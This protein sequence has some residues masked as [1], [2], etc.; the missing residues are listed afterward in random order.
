MVQ[1]NFNAAQVAPNVGFEPVPT[2]HYKVNITKSEEKPNSKGTGSYVELEMTIIDGEFRGR[3]VFDRLN[4]RNPNEQ[5]VSIAYG[6]LSAI[7]HVTGRLHIQDTQQL[8]GVPF[9]AVVTK[10]PRADKPELESNEIKGYKDIHGN[11]P[12]F[13]AAQ[14]QVP[15]GAPQQPQ[16]QPQ[17]APVQQPVYQPQQAPPQYMPQ[18]APVYQPQPQQAPAYQP[19]QAPPMQQAPAQQAPAQQAPAI[20][21]S[22]PPPWV[23]QQ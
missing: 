22:A 6:T 4:L 7:C 1:L 23:Q 8:H 17:Q 16:Y 12:G 11:D 20:D 21:P 9:I 13:A 3:K 15:G 10:L 2:G 5:A 19:Q 18:Q 14:G